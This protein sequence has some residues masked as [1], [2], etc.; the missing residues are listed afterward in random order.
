MIEILNYERV[1][2]NKV[3]GYVDIAL[4]PMSTPR[5][6]IRK[7]AHFQSG[8]RK[9]FNLASFS[10]ESG[11]KENKY[12]KF[13]QFEL[14]VYNGQLLEKL[15]EPVKQYCLENKIAE[16]ESLNFQSQNFDVNTDL[17]F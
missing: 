7:I 2:K 5:M 8:D 6:I 1:N 12:F 9:W 10:R 4:P 14:E 16:I 11:G 3:I 17:P 13:W 15:H